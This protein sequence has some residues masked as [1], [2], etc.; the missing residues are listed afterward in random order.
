[1]LSKCPK[2]RAEDEDEGEEEEEEIVEAEG[3]EVAQAVRSASHSVG[4][5]LTAPL[6][7][8]LS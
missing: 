7:T 6:A 1:M 8:P 5:F 3:A 2:E 4:P